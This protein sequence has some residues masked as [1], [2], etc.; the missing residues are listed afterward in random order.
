M[1]SLT[2]AD[3]VL[4]ALKIVYSFRSRWEGIIRG[5]SAI[6]ALEQPMGN[7][8]RTSKSSVRFESRRFNGR[9]SF[10]GPGSHSVF[11]SPPLIGYISDR[12]ANLKVPYNFLVRSRID[13]YPM[14]AYLANLFP[15]VF[16][17]VLDGARSSIVDLFSM[18]WRRLLTAYCHY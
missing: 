1:D 8:R 15:Y 14:T 16:I 2:T 7:Q 17:P 3:D 9:P 4:S 18:V 13:A 12:I 6:L 5:T 11:G 10:A